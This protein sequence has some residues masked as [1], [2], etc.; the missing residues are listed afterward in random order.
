MAAAVINMDLDVWRYLTSNRGAAS[1]H[2]GYTL[3]QKEDFDRFETLPSDW[4]YC[5]NEHGE[6]KGI[7]FPIKAKPRV[8][9]SPSRYCKMNGKL[10]KA[11]RM[12]IEKVSLHFVRK[13]CGIQNL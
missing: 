1:E 10:Q 2:K 5:L 8:S 6:G 7:D 4:Y 11:P 3:Y 12:P 13:A 9:W